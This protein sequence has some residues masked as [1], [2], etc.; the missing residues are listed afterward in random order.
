MSLQVSIV[1][2]FRVHA[3]DMQVRELTCG[4]FYELRGLFCA[5]LFG[6]YIRAPRFLET[7]IRMPE[8]EVESVATTALLIEDRVDLG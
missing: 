5:L 4:Y 2:V 8:G 6:V 7:P 3:L 1:L